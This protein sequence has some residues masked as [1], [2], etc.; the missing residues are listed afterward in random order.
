MPGNLTFSAVVLPDAVVAARNATEDAGGGSS[1]TVT[2]EL[3]VWVAPSSS[4]TVSAT[5]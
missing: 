5:V 2:V 4:V 1:E 3:V